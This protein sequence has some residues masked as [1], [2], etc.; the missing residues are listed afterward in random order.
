MSN[1]NFDEGKFKTFVRFLI[2]VAKE[3]RCVTYQE[4]E[5]VFG[6]SHRQVGYYAGKLGDLCIKWNWPRLNGLIIN[7]TDCVPSNGFD[8]YLRECRKSWGE[9]TCECW[10]KFH[11][12]ILKTK[13]VK[14]FTG[15]DRDI[16]NFLKSNKA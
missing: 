11:T 12:S 6:L 9:I 10:K 14:D 7:Q 8:Y 1:Y 2:Q 3:K 4:L 15:L 5:N 13:R 16:E